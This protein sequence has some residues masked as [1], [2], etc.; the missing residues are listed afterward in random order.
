MA[1]KPEISTTYGNL[2][3][4][5]SATAFSFSY[6][7]FIVYMSISIGLKQSKW[8]QKPNVYFAFEANYT[9]SSIVECIGYISA[10]VLSML[11]LINEYVT[12][13][14]NE[15]FPLLTPCTQVTRG[16]CATLTI[17]VGNR[18]TGKRC[19]A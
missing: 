11:S 19:I 12:L 2:R 10:C 9:S 18:F 3:Y 6:V 7:G 8:F 1:L 14:I 15:F 13:L 16:D 5:K 4:L 17:L